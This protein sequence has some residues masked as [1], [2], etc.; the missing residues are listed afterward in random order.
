M[1]EASALAEREKRNLRRELRSRDLF[2]FSISAVVILDTIGQ[3]AA[4][5]APG[6]TLL[7]IVAALWFVPYALIAAEIGAAFPEEGG[8]YVWV[9]LAFGRFLAAITA[10]IY[11]SS[12][13][14]WVG[15]SLLIVSMSAINDTF[16]AIAGSERYI[17]GLTFIWLAVA[18]SIVGVNVG[19]WIINVGGMA[20]IALLVFFSVTVLLYGVIHG[21]HGIRA[22]AFVPSYYAFVTIIPVAVFSFNGLEL[23]STASEEMINPQR[24]IPRVVAGCTV[25][26]MLLYGVAILA[27]LLILPIGQVTG[28][29][30]FLSASM[31]VLTVYG[32]DISPA[33]VVT[34]SGAGLVLSKLVAAVFVFGLFS[35]GASWMMGVDRALAMSCIDGA[36]VAALGHI[37]PRTGTP[38]R[39]TLLSGVTATITMLLAFSLTGNDA[40]KYFQAVLGLT[41][42]TALLAY[43]LVFPAAVRLRYSHGQIFSPYRIPGGNVGVWVCSILTTSWCL[44]GTL[45][46]L[47]P[48]FG[49]GLFGTA[50]D[51]DDALK[52]LNFRGQ[53]WPYELT[54]FGALLLIALAAAAF[55]L[56]GRQQ[57]RRPG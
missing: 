10:V 56:M 53:R 28:L 11:W 38:V 12:V 52:E 20:R 39:I 7:A 41:I 26:T 14:L 43:I 45:A 4:S 40:D 19:K 37:S 17:F 25:A 55:Y 29:T 32:G 33:G 42:S 54:Q 9:R 23:G 15:G 34:L 13:P 46:R 48:G 24:D 27:V 1:I 50:G 5:G 16:G 2:L 47:W 36:G 44:F 6:F 31:A 8:P 57:E 18:V 21:V 51:A 30:G 22:T 35:S 49:L 3:V